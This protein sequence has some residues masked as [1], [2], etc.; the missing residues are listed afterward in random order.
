MAFHFSFDTGRK[1]RPSRLR[2][3]LPE[4]LDRDG[5]SWD[6]RDAEEGRYVVRCAPDKDNKIIACFDTRKPHPLT[7][8]EAQGT[9]DGLPFRSVSEIRLDEPV[10]RGPFRFPT[11]EELA[12]EVRVTDLSPE[13][14]LLTGLAAESSWVRTVFASITRDDPEVRQATMKDVADGFLGKAV[15]AL[16]LGGDIEENVRS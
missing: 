9:E 14:G 15:A 4:I 10:H 2:F 1:S 6:A 8:L 3:D 11:R 7:S 5:D 16:V 12:A 13:S